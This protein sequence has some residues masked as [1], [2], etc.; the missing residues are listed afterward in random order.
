[1]HIT[2]FCFSLTHHN[3]HNVLKIYPWCHK[4][5]DILSR[6]GYYFQTMLLSSFWLSLRCSYILAIVNNTPIN[7]GVQLSFCK[8][9][10]FPLSVCPLVKF[11][12]HTKFPFLIIG[13]MSM[14]IPI[15]TEPLS[16]PI[17]SFLHISSNICNKFLLDNTDC[18][19][20]S[21]ICLSLMIITVN[22]FS[23]IYWAFGCI[24]LF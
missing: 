9:V 16:I 19:K 10:S 20:N 6:A 12:D 14:F 13:G 8:S 4:W 15:V 17:N 21:L 1:M 24:F 22:M 11:W 7:T 3:L 5:K 23:C 18:D 2:V